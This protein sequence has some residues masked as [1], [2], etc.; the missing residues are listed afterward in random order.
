MT[1]KVAKLTGLGNEQRCYFIKDKSVL[2]LP[3]KYLGKAMARDVYKLSVVAN[4]GDIYYLS[5]ADHSINKAGL[6]FKN[7]NMVRVDCPTK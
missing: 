3:D 4:I 7:G 1:G 6:R 2:E 5:L